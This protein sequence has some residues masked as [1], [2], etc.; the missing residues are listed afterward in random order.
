[1]KNLNLNRDKLRPTI[2]KY[3]DLHGISA[4][5]SDINEVSGP[6]RRV[7]ITPEVSSSFYIDFHYLNKGTTTIDITGG[8]Q[9]EIKE[10]I[11]QFLIE[12]PDCAIGD[13]H[14]KSKYFVAPNIN[15]EDFKVILE[16]I[17]SENTKGYSSEIRHSNEIHRFKGNYNEDLVIHYYKTTNKVMIQGRPLLLFNVTVSYLTELIDLDELSSVFNDYYEVKIEKSN[18]EHLYISYFPDCHDKHSIKIKKVLH[19]AIY[20]LQLEGDMFDYSYLAFP[21]FKALEGHL[22]ANL[23]IHGIKMENNRFTM[24][25]PEGNMGKYILD[26]QFQHLV[27]N[28]KNHLEDAYNYF[29]RNRHSLFHWADPSEAIDQTRIIENIGEAKSLIINTFHIINEYYII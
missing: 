10:Q 17:Q 12:D 19:Q 26:P 25:K 3:L 1:M 13:I 24:F 14:S 28:K 21:A 7:T 2:I 22:K 11:S 27:S 6:R 5:V 20:N 4:M 23:E 29:N 18:I 8:S 15:Y 9:R 16:L